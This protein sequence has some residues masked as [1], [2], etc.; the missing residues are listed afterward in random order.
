MVLRKEDILSGINHVQLVEIESLDDSAV[1]YRI[2]APVTAME[3][4]DTQR[5]IRKRVKE[6]LDKNK[7]KIPYPQI[8]VHNGK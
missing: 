6:T 5:V 3:Q 2:I 7:I 8:E 4:Y 1:T